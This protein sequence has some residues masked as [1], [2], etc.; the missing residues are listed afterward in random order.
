MS[1]SRYSYVRE[2]KFKI[3]IIQFKSLPLSRCNK[4]ITRI[5]NT[6]IPTLRIWEQIFNINDL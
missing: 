4:D 1:Y 5:I 6:D 3:F 2:K